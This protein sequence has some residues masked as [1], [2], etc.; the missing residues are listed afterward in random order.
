[1]KERLAFVAELER[2][3]RTMSELCRVFN[4]SRKTGHK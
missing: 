2:G 3:E 1:M 4:V